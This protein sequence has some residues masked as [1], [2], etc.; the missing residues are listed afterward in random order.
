MTGR[1]LE[2][3]RFD[4]ELRMA[5]EGRPPLAPLIKTHEITRG[6]EI[7]KDD[8]VRVTAVLN[9]HP[10]I[11]H[12]FAFRFDTA[13]RSF[14][15]SGDTRYSERVLALARGAD[16]LVHEAVSRD[17]W[18]R[19]NAPQPPAVVRHILASHTDVVEVGRLAAAAGVGT[20]VL[21]HLVPTE[22]QGAPT[23]DEWIAGARRHFKGRIVVGR[24]LLEL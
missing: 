14:V 11:E 12:S 18:E 2:A 20:L 15:F 3:H 16:I 23:D 17:F 13:D 22:G 6:G 5:D 9:D 8:R 19:P 4:L 10:P 21:S 24:D 1:L 7:Y